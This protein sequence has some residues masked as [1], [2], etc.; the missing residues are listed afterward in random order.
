[1]GVDDVGSAVD[2]AM[3]EGFVEGFGVGEREVVSVAEDL[4]ERMRLMPGEVEAMVESRWWRASG[5]WLG[6]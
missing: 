4:R 1:M 5:A 2:P 6:F 3:A